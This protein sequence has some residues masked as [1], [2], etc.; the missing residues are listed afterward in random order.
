MYIYIY[1]YIYICRLPK[2]FFE[3]ATKENIRTYQ[4][5]S[6]YG[7]KPLFINLLKFSNYGSN[8]VKKLIAAVK[9]FL[10]RLLR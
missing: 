4:K 1:I 5:K 8:Q 2:N 9:I 3:A 7:R 6:K 10:L